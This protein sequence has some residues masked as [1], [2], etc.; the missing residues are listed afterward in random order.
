VDTPAAFDPAVFDD[1]DDDE[2]SAPGL[3]G[4]LRV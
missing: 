2:G 1:G 4:W 3:F